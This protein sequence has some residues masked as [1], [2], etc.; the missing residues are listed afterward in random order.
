[1]RYE[2]KFC[3]CCIWP[4][5][6]KWL[7]KPIWR[8]GN[9]LHFNRQQWLDEEQFRRNERW[10]RNDV[11]G[12]VSVFFWGIVRHF[13]NGKT[14]FKRAEVSVFWNMSP[15]TSIYIFLRCLLFDRPAA[16]RTLKPLLRSQGSLHYF[17]LPRF[18]PILLHLSGTVR[19][20]DKDTWVSVTI[21]CCIQI[22]NLLANLINS[23][24]RKVTPKGV[25]FSKNWGLEMSGPT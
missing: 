4:S 22:T 24:L 8:T 18:A 11:N 1:M 14:T 10:S 20:S 16:E 5:D 13:M 6:F 17:L 21:T 9:V 2:L 19:N 7:S 12:N 25:I 15:C 3:K 23:Y